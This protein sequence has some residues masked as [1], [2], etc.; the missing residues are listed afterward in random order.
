MRRCIAHFSQSPSWYAR[1][2]RRL[3]VASAIAAVA[4][5]T[6]PGVRNASRSSA[7]PTTGEER[8]A[9][10]FE[11][12]RD[13]PPMVRAFLQRTPK[14]GDIHIHVTGAVYAESYIAWAAQ[15][16]MCVETA[17]STLK[18]CDRVKD[19]DCKPC[20]RTKDQ[21]CTSGTQPGTRRVVDAL[22]DPGLYS[23]LIDG[24]STRNLANQPQS[25]HDQFF[26]AFR[27]FW[28][29]GDGRWPDMVA[30]I[31]TRAAD[32]QV[33]YLEMMLTL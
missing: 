13:R 8:A 28:C 6:A 4:A 32:Q 20:D 29:V 15:D 2:T 19:E 7:P 16:G 10:W 30:E 23:A 5:C 12:H 17:T 18:P 27:R 3:I 26:A 14:G 21:N 11:A 1:R 22:H 24:L 33:A 25:G 9:A 31:A